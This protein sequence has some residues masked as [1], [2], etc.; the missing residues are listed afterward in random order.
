[1]SNK[2]FQF[3]VA[4]AI[5]LTVVV[6]STLDI[7]IPGSGLVAS[8]IDA[9]TDAITDTTPVEPAPVESPPVL[10]EPVPAESTSTSTEVTPADT[11]PAESTSTEVIPADT[12]PA[13][14]EPALTEPTGVSNFTEMLQAITNSVENFV[15]PIPA[16][17]EPTPAA[18]KGVSR[19]KVFVLTQDTLE[20]TVNEWLAVQQGIVVEELK[21]DAYDGVTYLIVINYH[22]S[23]IGNTPTRIKFFKS[24]GLDNSIEAPVQAF[25]SSL[26]SSQAVRSIVP[27]I[28]LAGSIFVFIVYE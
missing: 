15:E 8:V 12:T 19:L 13:P 21:V 1:M 5:V 7:K 9:I 11:A 28:G 14:I 10:I 26:N 20:S 6:L 27:A 24:E 4:G 17:T 22:T 23:G 2:W 18:P 3:V 16:P 25:L